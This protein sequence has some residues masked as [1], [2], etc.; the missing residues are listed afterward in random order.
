MNLS[1]C[2][3]CPMNSV[4][5]V[6]VST[7]GSGECELL[8]VGNSPAWSDAP[9]R[10]PYTGNQY[11]YIWQLLSTIGVNFY[12]TTLYK[13]KS[14]GV[15]P[16][17][18]EQFYDEV[19]TLRP[20][21]ILF[22]GEKTLTTVLPEA[23]F[24]SYRD[25]AHVSDLFGDS[26]L[27]A[28]YDPCYVTPDNEMVYNRFIDDLV[29]AC[30]HAMSYK[31]S[32]LYR[33]LTISK[34]QFHRIVDVWLND[35]SIEYV[36]FDSESNGLDPL[37]DG[38]KITSFSVAVDEKVGYNIFLYHPD[39]LDS[40]TDEDRQE[41]IADAK[42]L[43]TQK[44]IIVHH[45][46]HEHRLIKVLWGFTPNIT[47][48]TMY[49]SYILYLSY[50]GI[51]H[52]LKYLS[53]RFI[54]MP[55]WEEV[56]QRFVG[57]FKKLNRHKSVDES[58]C[59]A[60][61]EE[62]KD[63]AELSVDDVMR[64]FNIIKDPDYVLK[65]EQ[66]DMNTDPYYW[67]VPY[68][69][70]E[71]Y[72]GMDAIAPLLLMRKFKPT[73][74][75][76]EGLT[77]SYRL[78]VEG[79]EVFANIE[80]HGVRLVALDT[81]S[82]LYD[83]KLEETLLELRNYK[84]VHDWEESTQSIFNPGST[85]VLAHIMYDLMKFPVLEYTD[86]GAPKTS[87]PVMIDLIKKMR[88]ASVID[89]YR[90]N[91][92]LTLRDY[93]KF[94]KIKSAYWEGLKSFIHEGKSFDGHLCEFYDIE[95]DVESKGRCDII[96]PGYMLHGTD[97]VV[98]GTLVL[99]KTAEEDVPHEV[100]IETLGEC[101]EY[102]EKGFYGLKEPIKVW[103]S[104]EWREPLAFYYGGERDVL[105]ICTEDGGSITCTPEHPLYTPEGYRHA[106]DIVVGDPVYRCV[107]DQFNQLVSYWNP[108]SSTKFVGVRKVY[109]LCM[110]TPEGED[111][112]D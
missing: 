40:I 43:L 89:E 79:A 84:E 12:V 37:L 58:L 2:A 96:N 30:R 59:Q 64:F 90:L 53:G 1:I 47:E 109:D 85:K 107:L 97:C 49:M 71:S 66:C 29:Y 98:E 39:L 57:V 74:D 15:S 24:S 65:A 33:S 32:P 23:T 67:L 87:E 48:D 25:Y 88:E 111:E 11:N 94:A 61:I 81:W 70:M 20:R 62:M 77:R 9:S 91:F 69:V 42:R 46:K 103:D 10:V 95:G 72:A 92:L 112:V 108:V 34:S 106:E 86:K 21:C 41:I 17:C 80:L 73:I 31:T 104:D 36:S 28:T 45:A 35:P 16:T 100:P 101:V 76:D 19:K 56:L 22:M 6:Q 44:K 50:P 60:I 78:M 52:G 26:K 83:K 55:P 99:T 3:R 75:S 7:V 27:L 4:N 93:K 18:I 13:C 8:L 38:L 63:I 110:D 54:Q 5:K 82:E 14:T 105:E 68:K 102:E 51:S